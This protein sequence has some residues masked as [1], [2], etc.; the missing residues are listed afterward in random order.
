M[1]RFCLFLPH[2]PS[3]GQLGP[4]V[5]DKKVYVTFLLIS[6]L[7][8]FPPVGWDHQEARQQKQQNNWFFS[9]L[10][11]LTHFLI[12]LTFFN[13]GSVFCVGVCHQLLGGQESWR[14][15]K[16]NMFETITFSSI[17]VHCMSLD[18][19]LWKWEVRRRRW[20][21]QR[22]WMERNCSAGRYLFPMICLLHALW[23]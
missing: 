19:D 16:N 13:A 21:R 22:P 15:T 9:S 7:P 10:G 5:C 17:Y 11:F 12:D 2:P 8:P 14:V 3:P 23:E 18:L 1:W 4:P 6:A 20:K